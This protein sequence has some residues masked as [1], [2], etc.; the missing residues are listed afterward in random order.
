MSFR[1]KL[2]ELLNAE[3]V[4]EGL[5]R[6]E[7]GRKR[8][9]EEREE[10]ELER[11]LVK[12]QTIGEEKLLPILELINETYLKNKGEITASTTKIE[13]GLTTIYCLKYES[14]L[15]WGRWWESYGEY[16]QPHGG[17]ELT[18]SLD[19]SLNVKIIAGKIVWGSYDKAEMVNLQDDNWKEQLEDCIY[20]KLASKECA[21]ANY[22]RSV[23]DRY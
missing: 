12:L 1:E 15:S 2:Q 20:S 18:L 8:L 10:A 19:S 13:P 11:E 4:G 7:E 16:D 5:K 9:K 21:W 17:N 6:K 22:P 23:M 14:Y 3:R